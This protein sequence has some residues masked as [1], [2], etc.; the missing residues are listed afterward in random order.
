MRIAVTFDNQN[1]TIF[2]HFGRTEYFKIYEVED[3]KVLSSR[4][5]ST[6]G[7]GHEALAGLL[8]EGTV[9]A[10]ICGGLGQGMMNALADA[11]ITVI[12]GVSGS[13]DEAVERYLKGE[14]QPEEAANCDSHEHDKCGHGCGGCGERKVILS[15]KNAGKTCRVHY[16]GTFNDGSQFDSSYD[17]GTPL[18]FVSGTGMMIK[19]FD[20]AVVDMEVGEEKDIHLM[21]EEAYGA[22][23]PNAVLK[24]KLT[25]LPGAGNLSV[26]DQVALRNSLG[27]AFPVRVTEKTDEEITFDANSEMAGKELNFHIELVSVEE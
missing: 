3:R 17:R 14:L 27:H 21:P 8:S 1:G 9:E 20:Q 16:R 18:E 26:G 7:T 6:G 5:E 19:G 2:Q 12:P 24:L 4:V 15:G 25:D 13:A 23:D 22:Y 10:V 11:G